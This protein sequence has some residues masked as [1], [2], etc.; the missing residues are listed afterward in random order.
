MQSD[1]AD[2]RLQKTSCWNSDS[3][4]RMDNAGGADTIELLKLLGLSCE[5]TNRILCCAGSYDHAIRPVTH[6]C[7]SVSLVD[8]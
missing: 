4:C 3:I 5:R 2:D 1:A 6:S 7:S 8:E